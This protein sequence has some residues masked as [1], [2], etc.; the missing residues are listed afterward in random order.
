MLSEEKGHLFGHFAAP[1]SG[2]LDFLLK[3]NARGVKFAG[4][5]P[6]S[7]FRLPF[8]IVLASS[9]TLTGTRFQADSKNLAT[10]LA[11]KYFYLVGPDMTSAKS[12]V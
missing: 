12:F 6:Y 10:Q 11:P 7:Q 3:M 5:R 8:R 4:N 2:E 9:G 1:F